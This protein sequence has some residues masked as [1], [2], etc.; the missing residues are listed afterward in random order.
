MKNELKSI[1]LGYGLGPLKFG[2]SRANVKMML[3]EP[4]NIEKY[5]YTDDDEN[6]TESWDYDELSLSLS[7]DEEDNYRLMLISITSPFYELEGKSLIGSTEESVLEHLEALGMDDLELEI[8][9]EDDEF[10]NKLIEIEEK[11]INFWIN[12]G[13]VDEIQWSPFFV[14]DD[15]VDWPE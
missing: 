12:D 6:L 8:M 7:F 3:G 9:A 2:M 14:D 13:V 15:T 4:S 5:S 11:S 1:K 10:E